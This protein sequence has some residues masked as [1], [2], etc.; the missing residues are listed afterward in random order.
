M[1]TTKQAAATALSPEE[2]GECQQVRLAVVMYGGVSLAIYMNGVAQEILRLVR[3]T[4]VGPDESAIANRR[5]FLENPTGTER[6]YRR[7]GQ[8]VRRN[9][10]AEQK[11]PEDAPI[12]T[13]FTVDILSGTSAGG[14]NAVFLAKALAIDGDLDSLRDLWMDEAEIG[15][16]VNDSKSLSGTTLTEQS[17]PRSLLN[18]R[19]MYEKLVD[20]FDGVR[21][22]SDRGERGSPYVDELDLFVTATDLH[23]TVLPVRLADRMIYE[24]RYRNVFHFRYDERHGIDDFDAGNG[25]GIRNR[26]L[27]FASRA[28]SAFPFAFEPMTL[29]QA[30][31]GDRDQWIEF[32]RRQ[33]HPRVRTAREARGP[34]SRAFGDGGYLDNKPFSYAIETLAGRSSDSV[35]PVD[36]KL[37]YVEP[38]PKQPEKET[39]RTDPPDAIENV[40]LALLS[41]PRY[42]TIR[43][44]LQSLLG[45]NR[46]VRW[47]DTILERMEFDVLQRYDHRP[48]VPDREGFAALDLGDMIRGTDGREGRGNTYGAYHRLKVYSLTDDIAAA[49]AA[50]GGFDRDSEEFEAIREIV[51]AWRDSRYAE[52]RFESDR[53]TQNRFLVEFD[54]PFRIRRLR[55]VR[56][57]ADELLRLDNKT[58]D[59]LRD[60]FVPWRPEEKDDREV[61]SEALLRLKAVTREVQR[62]LVETRERLLAGPDENPLAAVVGSLGLDLE[63]LDAITEQPTRNARR[64]RAAKICEERQESIEDAIAL[65]K[66]QI[67]E[68][69]DAASELCK[70]AVRPDP[71]GYDPAAHRAAKEALWHY[72]ETYGEYDMILYPILH[73]TGI[74]EERDR[75]EVIRV[76]PLDAPALIDESKEERR[77]LA[78]TAFGNFGAFLD[79]GWRRNDFLWG[80]L[81]GAE[82][83]ISA[84]LP[85]DADA[86]ARDELIGRAHREIIQE[87]LGDDDQAEVC[88]LL[89]RT[90]LHV[91]K[92]ARNEAALREL[93][94][95]STDG[96]THP[97]LEAILRQA[98]QD[99][100]LIEFFETRYEVDRNL[101]RA[102]TLQV[103]SR[104]TKVI[105][106]M[107]DSLAS[108]RSAGT[109]RT[110]WI[111]RLA[112]AFWGIVE[113]AVPG[114]FA[115][116]LFR[117]VLKVVYAFEAF[118]FAF[119]FLLGNPGVQRWG[120]L[121]FIATLGVHVVVSIV[122]DF[123]ARRRGFVG[124]IMGLLVAVGL[125]FAAFGAS[126]AFAPWILP[127][128]V[129]RYGWVPLAAFGALVGVVALAR[130]Y[131]GWVAPKLRRAWRRVRGLFS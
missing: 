42:E 97:A 74:G 39:V 37:L 72:Y 89:A 6:V 31:D 51:R 11:A 99:D 35:V 117:H 57:K 86:A 62:T 48:E 131:L 110:R 104:A 120:L 113:V 19:R 129:E 32:F 26:F 5:P 34:E 67:R 44:D 12:F 76:S 115:N 20:A 45:H 22:R 84:M 112:Q 75:V 119:G 107:F 54:L 2:R 16:L 68:A 59:V 41:I 79:R 122:E 60:A 128:G 121:A 98:L 101:D 96:V 71:E 130:L 114:S 93:L 49:F 7:L 14:I 25:R 23:G 73:S 95:E 124:W 80:R 46:L 78:G 58:D 47:V 125:V 13:E 43:E 105:G 30:E 83:L 116:L 9:R 94:E 28:T 85:G 87:E 50:A 66:N 126:V 15:R 21:P 3:A 17:P 88:R 100:R 24:R 127:P 77:K 27:A 29:T 82:R 91:R 61:F 33:L 36:R 92:E 69:A 1:P 18:S 111:S 56:R 118:L 103:A 102:A 63:D 8:I 106:K 52:Y 90:S 10:P 123:M 38:A 64:D 4:A 70:D 109:T 55:F 65:L 53:P 81:D 40:G 108:A